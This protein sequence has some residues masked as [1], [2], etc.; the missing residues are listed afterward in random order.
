MPEQSRPDEPEAS[1]PSG[2]DTAERCDFSLS[3]PTISSSAEAALAVRK[4]SHESA[5]VCGKQVLPLQN[6]RVSSCFPY[7]LCRTAPSCRSQALPALVAVGAQS[8]NANEVSARKRKTSRGKI[9][10]ASGSWVF[11]RS[12]KVVIIS[13]QIGF[14]LAV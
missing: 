9:S 3:D 12:G 4:T 2:G 11:K 14:F 10:L 8:T 1:A 7:S 13:T 5:F 6:Y